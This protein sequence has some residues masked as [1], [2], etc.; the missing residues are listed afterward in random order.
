MAEPLA[1]PMDSPQPRGK[2]TEMLS[3][4]Y[5]NV[6]KHCAAS[7]KSM[8]CCTNIEIY[9]HKPL[10]QYLQRQINLYSYLFWNQ[11]RGAPGM[12][13]TLSPL[14]RSHANDSCAG[15][16]PFALAIC[17]I[18]STSSIFCT[19]QRQPFLYG[20]VFQVICGCILPISTN[21]PTGRDNCP[22]HTMSICTKTTL[23]R[24]GPKH[25]R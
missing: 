7:S 18:L 8:N 22:L 13:N 16:H 3:S 20:L 15:V 6:T 23:P 1:H 11:E 21:T 5:M 4:V 24:D 12:G 14:C 25:G 17:F 10:E 2:T 19:H 9:Q